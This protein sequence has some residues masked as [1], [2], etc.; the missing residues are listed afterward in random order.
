MIQVCKLTETCLNE[1]SNEK[2]RAT[3]IDR[4]PIPS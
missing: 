2:G 1:V 3:T 4:Q